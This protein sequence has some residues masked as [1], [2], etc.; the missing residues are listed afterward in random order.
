MRNFTIMKQ[1]FYTIFLAFALS[2]CGDM[3]ED[4][5]PYLDKGEKIYVGKL[6]S[7]KVRSGKNRIQIEGLMPY[8]ITQEKCIIS[9]IDPNN[10][11]GSKEFPITRQSENDEFKFVIDGLL[12]GQHDFSI[13]TIDAKG[14]TS[15]KVEA[16]GF[17]FGEIY[18]S[19]LE[20]RK[21]NRITSQPIT[22]ESGTIWQAS[23]N[24]LAINSNEV[25]GCNV[26]YEL[27][28]G[29]FKEIYVP[30]NELTTG[31]TGYKPSGTL[32]WN[33]AFLPDS[34]SIDLFYTKK[35][36]MTLPSND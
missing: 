10:A 8:G 28:D 12:E 22:T 27:M 32:R 36:E 19:T 2:S 21:I 6:D 23:I 17:S 14:N 35:I 25:Q 7:I 16:N 33:T 18:Q 29:S 24:W 31:F 30:V 13:I 1:L 4:I 3:L 34:T 15:I 20:N 11:V 9:W 5:Q 26:E